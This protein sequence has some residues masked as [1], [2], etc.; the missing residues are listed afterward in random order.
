MSFTPTHS[1]LS[2]FVEV[3]TKPIK[4]APEKIY[5]LDSLEKEYRAAAAEWQKQN[6]NNS[7][8]NRFL[9]RKFGFDSLY[10]PYSGKL[11]FQPATLNN[12]KPAQFTEFKIIQ[13][14]EGQTC[15]TTKN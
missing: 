13:T 14:P 11:D 5:N 9:L 8:S 7:C 1:E 2:S 15:P 12:I 10:K 6:N 4:R 3:S